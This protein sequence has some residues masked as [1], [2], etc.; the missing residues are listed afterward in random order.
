[1]LS[2]R[3]CFNSILLLIFLLLLKPIQFICIVL[4][5]IADVMK[6]SKI[7]DIGLLLSSK[8][9]S[10]LLLAQLSPIKH[11]SRAE[12]KPHLQG[13][14]WPGAAG[15]WCP[16]W[17]CCGR[18]RRRCT[19][20][21]ASPPPSCRPRSPRWGWRP[22]PGPC[23]A[24]GAR[25]GQPGSNYERRSLVIDLLGLAKGRLHVIFLG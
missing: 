16:G 3:K 9:I 13:P 6:T 7:Q 17:S 5:Q 11:Q 10:L 1:M 8:L 4:A 23:R 15:T 21:P 18:W 12:P 20:S 2:R 25:H 14:G 24:A 19:A 22:G